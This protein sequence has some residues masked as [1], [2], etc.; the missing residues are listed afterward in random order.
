MWWTHGKEMSHWAN[1]KIKWSKREIYIQNTMKIWTYMVYHHFKGTTYTNAHA[2]Y[3]LQVILDLLDF[4]DFVTIIDL[5]HCFWSLHSLVQGTESCIVVIIPQ[6]LIAYG[7]NPTEK[8]LTMYDISYMYIHYC[9]ITRYL[10]SCSN[11]KLNTNSWIG[12]I[13]CMVQVRATIVYILSA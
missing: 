11:N 8:Y 9:Y 13:S 7:R 4:V 12:D 5:V 6:E 3:L 1:V 10:W 2:L